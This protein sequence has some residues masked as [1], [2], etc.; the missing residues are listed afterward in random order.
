MAT[1]TE[2]DSLLSRLDAATN[3][4]AAELTDLKNQIAAGGLT[5]AQESDIVSR[6]G[7]AIATLEAIG[8]PGDP[9][10]GPVL[11]PSPETPPA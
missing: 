5:A 3:A 2:F 8:K 7:T 9:V 6:L 4:L 11:P 1:P 10:P